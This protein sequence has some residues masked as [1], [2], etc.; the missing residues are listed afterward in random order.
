MSRTALRHAALLLLIL[1]LN[2]GVS[3]AQSLY[4][5]GLANRALSMNFEDMQT[6]GAINLVADFAGFG[7]VFIE[8]PT[9]RQTLRIQNRG[10]I[11]ALNQILSTENLV[12]GIHRGVVYIAY[13]NTEGARLVSNRDLLRWY[14]DPDAFETVLKVEDQLNLESRYR[15]MSTA[16]K[17]IELVRRAKVLLGEVNEP[18]DKIHKR[19]RAPPPLPAPTPT[20]PG[21]ADK[22]TESMYLRETCINRALISEG[23][24]LTSKLRRDNYA[25]RYCKDEVREVMNAIIKC[26]QQFSNTTCHQAFELG[27]SAAMEDAHLDQ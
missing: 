23:E 7:V 15:Q 27:K 10:W 24:E 18:S 26:K 20:A 21:I 8:K 13:A 3:N 4:D 11:E 22:L 2:A 5:L 19:Y 6:F 17:N 1:T 9:G 25:R 12:F 14:T 16:N